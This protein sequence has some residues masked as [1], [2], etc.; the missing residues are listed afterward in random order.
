MNKDKS[1]ICNNKFPCVAAM[2]ELCHAML[3]VP[4]G[5]ETMI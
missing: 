5:I 3:K 2:I 1:F 4:Q